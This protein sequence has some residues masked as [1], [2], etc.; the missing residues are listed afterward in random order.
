MYEFLKVGK[1]M[2]KIQISALYKRSI[3]LFFYENIKFHFQKEIY[4]RKNFLDSLN[5]I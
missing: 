1:K 2:A 4:K 3:Y 5:E